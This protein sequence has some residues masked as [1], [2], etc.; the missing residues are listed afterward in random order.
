MFVGAMFA[1]C[2]CNA[3][4]II[5]PDGTRVILMKNP[6]WQSEFIGLYRTLVDS[7]WI[8]L[9]FPMFFASNVFYTYQT[10]EMN[11][12]HFDTRTRA[13][14][15]LLYWLAQIVGAFIFGFALDYNKARRTVR[16]KAGLAALAVLTFAIW[17]GGWAWQKQQVTREVA[18]NDPNYVTVDWTDG[19]K[20]YIGPMFLY[21]F[22]GSNSGRKAANLAGFYKGIQSAGAAIFWRIDSLKKP[23][24]TVF[25]ATV[26]TTYFLLN[27]FRILI[28]CTS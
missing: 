20:R 2:L 19:G 1:L 6:T 25:G 14:N 5:R 13:L 28:V 4:K 22:Y 7:P 23:Y 9:L 21:F 3:N 27:S 11:A 15:G 17:G 12:P 26:S 10:N 16:A 8:L 18:E 24:N